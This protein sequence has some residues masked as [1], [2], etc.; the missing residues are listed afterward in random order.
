M[1]SA[2][3]PVA[4][5]EQRNVRP[6]FPCRFLCLAFDFYVTGYI[7]ILTFYSAQ[8][9]FACSTSHHESAI[10]L[11][12]PRLYLPFPPSSLP[13]PNCL[14]ILSFSVDCFRFSRTTWRTIPPRFFNFYSPYR[15]MPPITPIR[16]VF[17][18]FFIRFCFTPFTF[19]ASSFRF[20]P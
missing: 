13:I 18:L 6:V 8:F 17:L 15:F 16:S 3:A 20:V 4:N 2:Y 12:F 11:E 9:H 14:R 5:S 1:I 19:R 10:S 7:L